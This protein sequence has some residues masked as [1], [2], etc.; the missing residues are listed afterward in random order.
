MNR[1]LVALSGAAAIFAGTAVAQTTVTG[2]GDPGVDIPAVQAAVDKGGPVLLTGHFSFDAPPTVT[3]APS[4]LYSGTALGT[5]LVSKAVEISGARDDRGEMTSIEA[6]TNPFYVNAPG[7][8]VSI[9]GLHFIHSK[10]VAIRVVAAHG[11]TIASNRVDGVSRGVANAVGIL[12]GTTPMPPNAADLTQTEN[13]SGTLSITNNDIDMQGG[14]DGNY[15]CILMYALG[16]SPD[17]EVDLY[18]LGNDI[19]NST[20]RPIDINS[21][22]GRV[23]IERNRVTTGNIGFDVSPSGS[24]VHIV[25]PGQFLI[26]H[27]QFDCGWTSGAHAGIRLFSKTGQV[28][29]YAIVEDNDMTMATPD[30]T[31]FTAT[32]SAIEVRGPGIGNMVLNN[33]VRGRANFALSVIADGGSPQ[34]TTFLMNNTQEF[35]AAQAMVFVDAGG[36]NTVLVGQPGVVE[37]HGAG[38][39]VVT[40]SGNTDPARI[41]Q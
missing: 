5:I 27:N 11:L 18:V 13:V 35:S 24:V 15:L 41:N 1:I 16:K 3:E 17:H 38:T 32:S 36:S 25:G 9:Q 28:L 40:W 8:H 30:G 10:V 33:R 14:A 23:Y 19:R 29:S 20:E 39:A 12:V 22:G 37:D 21:I 4:I 34:T 26:A 2:T 31:A 7:A 6:G